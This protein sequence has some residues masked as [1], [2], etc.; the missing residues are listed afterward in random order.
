VIYLHFYFIL[1]YKKSVLINLLKSLNVPLC[2]F[3][4][5]TWG[6]ALQHLSFSYSEHL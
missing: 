2:S 1:F 6:R 5:K 4:G 3:T